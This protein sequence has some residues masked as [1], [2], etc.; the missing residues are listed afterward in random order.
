MTTPLF[1]RDVSLKLKL[2]AATAVEF[3]CD[4][5][6]AEVLTTPGDDVTYET[7]CA[8]GS[9]SNIG[10]SSYQL[11]I[12][13]LQDWSS[14]GLANFLWAH[15]GELATFQ[16]QAHG[17]AVV[18][19]ASAPG[20][21]GEVRLVAP[22]YGGEASTYAEL[23]VTMPCTNKPTMAVAAFPAMAEAEAPAE[24]DPAVIAAEAIAAAEGQT[25][26]A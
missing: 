23:D 14:T 25:V 6:L 10:R 4:A 13:A 20:M 17:T 22:N 2:G 15:E 7:L 24:D 19:S 1:M 18:P 5:H 8:T 26:A 3:N 12:V 21:T 9:F 16:Y 11:H